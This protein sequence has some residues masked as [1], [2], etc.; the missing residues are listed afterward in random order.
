M[1]DR[2][3]LIVV[4]TVCALLLILGA[5]RHWRCNRAPQKKLF[6]TAQPVTTTIRHVVVSTGV[7]RIKDSSRIGSLVP[8]TVQEILVKENE[9]VCKGQL[10]ATL[11]NGKADTAIRATRGMLLQAHADY[12]YARSI[13]EREKVLFDQGHRSMQEFEKVSHTMQLAEGK[14]MS[15][16]AQFDAAKIE[17]DNTQIRAT[18][19]GVIISVGIKKGVKV[20][21]DLDATVLFEIARDITKMEAEID[22]DESDVAHIKAGQKV[23]FTVDSYSHKRFKAHIQDISYAPIRRKNNNDLSYRATIEVDNSS[24]LLRPGMTIHATVKIDKVKDTLGIDAQA[25]Y[26]DTQAVKAVAKALTYDVEELDDPARKKLADD[27]NDTKCIWVHDGSRFKEKAVTMGVHDNRY[28]QA[29]KGITPE[30][31]YLIDVEQAGSFD[32]HYKKMFR[33]AL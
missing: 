5:I 18:D 2:R 31:S 7:L 17:F 33:G 25:V 21:T 22:I 28:I 12:E 32:E 23:T 19:D 6:K 29:C 4:G 10:L 1:L 3:T 13:Y 27:N 9:K 20:T 24:L 11:D 26:L 16:Q 8:G 30:E 15:A 14:Q